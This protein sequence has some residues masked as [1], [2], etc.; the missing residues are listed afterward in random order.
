[1]KKYTIFY[2]LFFVV[3]NQA[4]AQLSCESLLDRAPVLLAKKSFSKIY[5]EILSQVN[6]MRSDAGFDGVYSAQR[7]PDWNAYNNVSNLLKTLE[8]PLYN[9]LTNIEKLSLKKEFSLANES[10]EKWLAEALKD[11]NFVSTYK[12]H[13]DKNYSF[14]EL[15]EKVNSKVG[16]SIYPD[17]RLNMVLSNRETIIQGEKLLTQLNKDFNKDFVELS[18]YK[19]L[20]EYK[21]KAQTFDETSKKTADLLENQVLVAMHRPENARFWIPLTGFQNQRITGSSR[22]TLSPH[23]RNQAEAHLLKVNQTDY[24]K[25]SFRLMPKYAEVILGR[26]VTDLKNGDSASH[27]GSDLWI[28]KKSVVEKRATWTPIDSLSP[29]LQGAATN[30]LNGFIPWSFRSLATPFLYS[31]IKN[32]K[33]FNPNGSLS[34]LSFNSQKW[35]YG[36]YYMEV[37]IYGDVSINDVSA[38]HFRANPPDAEMMKYLKSKNIEVFDDRRGQPVKYTG[39]L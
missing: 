20:E 34:E 15:L 1:M 38:L 33:M 26:E 19:S 5:T 27:Y 28:M 31:Q 24:E 11:P 36:G 10:V 37:Q 9:K 16:V 29:G 21:K 8:S 35:N 32:Y 7:N 3:S 23:Y 17:V 12:I 39:G 13:L 4:F 30:K 18:G 2:A 14:F 6:M 25:N 22:G